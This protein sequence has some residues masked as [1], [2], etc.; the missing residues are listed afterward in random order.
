MPPYHSKFNGP[1]VPSVCGCALLA[2]NTCYRGPAPPPPEGDAGFEDIVDEAIKGFRWNIL[3]RNFEVLGDA[4]RVL[5]YLTLWI[6]KCLT[7][8]SQA[9]G[10]A[11]ATRQLETMAGEE[12]PGPGDPQFVL[13][14]LFSEG[15]A[16]DSQTAKAYLKQ[17]RLETLA[18]LLPVLYPDGQPNK[19]WFQFSKR[20][21]M[22]IAF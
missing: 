21:F 11:D 3:F 9:N 14:P 2:V 20:K 7:V 10:F 17:L 18:R 6:Q 12:L 13:T 1:H 22:N 4:D 8:A 15:S 19:W 5:V 16:Q